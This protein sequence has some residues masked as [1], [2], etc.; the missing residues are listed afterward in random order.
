MAFV[1]ATLIKKK[2]ED[3]LIE[4]NEDVPL[5]KKYKVDPK[6]IKTVNLRNVELGRNHEKDMI[7]CHDGS[8]FPIELLKIGGP[9]WKKSKH[10]RDL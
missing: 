4:V 3:G 10:K 8:L 6:S 5:G 2:S 7:R 1:T 9:R